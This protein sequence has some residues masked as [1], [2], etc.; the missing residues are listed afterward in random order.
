M[1]EKRIVYV[2]VKESGL[3]PLAPKTNVLELAPLRKGFIIVVDGRCCPIHSQLQER[4]IRELFIELSTWVL[5]LITFCLDP[6]L[7][8]RDPYGQRPCWILD[9]VRVIDEELE[10]FV[11]NAR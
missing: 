8:Q 11:R 2:G 6:R 5:Q 4:F 10:L 7:S 3:F 1:A 9:D